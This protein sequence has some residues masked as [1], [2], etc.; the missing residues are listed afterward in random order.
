MIKRIIYLSVFTIVLS[1][2]LFSAYKIIRFSMN[3]KP[4]K[5][6]YDYNLDYMN[7]DIEKKFL[8]SLNY[9]IS[10]KTFPYKKEDF[11][12]IISEIKP[13]EKNIIEWRKW[14]K[15]GKRLILFYNS[16]SD[17]KD[18][19]NYP[20]NNTFDELEVNSNEELFADVRKIFVNSRAY[21][22]LRNWKIFYNYNNVLLKNDYKIL[23]CRESYN[24]GEIIYIADNS[25]FSDYSLLKNNNAMLLNNLVKNYIN[26]VIVFDQVYDSKEETGPRTPYFLFTGNFKYLFLQLILI[27]VIFFLVFIKR[28]G[29]PVDK[30]SFERRSLLGHLEAAGL[31]FEKSR[32]PAVISRIFDRYF[33]FRLKNILKIRYLS[34]NDL[35]NEIN[36]RYGLSK[37]EIELFSFDYNKNI[38]QKEINREKFI[39]KLK[40]I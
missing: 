40:G 29:M 30:E 18:N 4:E 31:F 20:D 9:K 5:I 23:I 10:I 26:D 11:N 14:V 24:G 34:K 35:F 2:V 15:K 33:L 32:N 36:K 8:A 22:D 37:N 12:I 13:N 25:I 7:F 21:I 3:Y 39:R 6:E 27:A 19:Y 1:A 17:L 16:E 38:V 28:F